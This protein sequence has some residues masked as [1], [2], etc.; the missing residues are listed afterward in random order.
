MLVKVF[1]MAWHV[2][3]WLGWVKLK[4]LAKVFAWLGLAGRC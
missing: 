3:A 1:S 4:V 2:W